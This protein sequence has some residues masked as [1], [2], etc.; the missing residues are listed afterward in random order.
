ML[1]RARDAEQGR[2]AGWAYLVEPVG[3]ELRSTSV[4]QLLLHAGLGDDSDRRKVRLGGGIG[5]G[6]EE[7]PAAQVRNCVQR[8]ASR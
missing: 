2:L 6:G 5:A 1:K 3:I 7:D 8:H 4:P